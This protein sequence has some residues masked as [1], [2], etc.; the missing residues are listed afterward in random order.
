MLLAIRPS[1][2]TIILSVWMAKKNALS[3]LCF[4]IIEL[5]VERASLASRIFSRFVMNIVVVG[6]HLDFFQKRLFADEN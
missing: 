4:G 5:K 2:L 6:F 3:H 1:Y